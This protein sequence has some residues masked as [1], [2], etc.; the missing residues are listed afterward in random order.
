MISRQCRKNETNGKLTVERA[1]G[2]LRRRFY[3]TRRDA[4]QHV[5]GGGSGSRTRFACWRDAEACMRGP[6]RTGVA[7]ATGNLY[8]HVNDSD[9]HFACEHRPALRTNSITPTVV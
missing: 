4:I 7:C 1:P 9:C 8:P 6:S 5:K 3:T 2:Y